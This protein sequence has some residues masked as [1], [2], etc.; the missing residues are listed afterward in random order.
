MKAFGYAEAT[1]KG[2]SSRSEAQ[3][4]NVRCKLLFSE[5]HPK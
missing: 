1:T 2:V 4:R 3:K 5:L